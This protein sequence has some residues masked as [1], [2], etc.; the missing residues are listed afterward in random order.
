M[1]LC[2]PTHPSGASALRCETGNTEDSAL[3][4]ATQSNCCS[5]IDFLSPEPCPQQSLWL[6]ALI[7]RQEVIQQHEYKS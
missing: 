6:N 5:A 7:A 4:R 3:V 1:M 2:F